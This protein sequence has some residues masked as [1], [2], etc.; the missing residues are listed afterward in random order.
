MA[1]LP[2]DI[3]GQAH[4]TTPRTVIFAGKAAPGY[5]MAKLIIR[6][7][8]DVA[9]IVN[10]GNNVLGM[11]PHPER[12]FRARQHS[13]RPDSWKDRASMSN[14]VSPVLYPNRPA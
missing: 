2:A 6:L 14:C 13:W 9:G 10:E 7:I 3:S 5:W 11:M 4:D 1:A 8:N 12:V